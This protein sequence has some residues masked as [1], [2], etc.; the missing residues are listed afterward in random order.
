MKSVVVMRFWLLF[1]TEIVK[2]RNNMRRRYAHK[3]FYTPSAFK[4]NP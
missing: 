1:E 2:S 4:D 3:L